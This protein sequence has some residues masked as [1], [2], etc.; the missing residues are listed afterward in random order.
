[1]QT[2]NEIIEEFE[3]EFHKFG[4]TRF[5]HE[6]EDKFRD[7]N[8]YHEMREYS[9]TFLKEKLTQVVEDARKCKGIMHWVN[10]CGECPCMH[11]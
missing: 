11:E 1:M 2:I 8:L 6:P 9:A 5:T 3:K 7:D 10:D 4:Q